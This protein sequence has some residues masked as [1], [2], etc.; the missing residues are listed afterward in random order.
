MLD[1]DMILGMDWFVKYGATIDCRRKM[2]TFEPEGEDPYVF[3]GT[4]HGPRV[5]MISVLRARGL[6][7][8]GCLGFLAIVVETTQVMPV[9]PEETI[10]VCEFLDVFPEDLPGLPPHREIEFVIELASGTERVSGAPYRMTPI[11]LKELKVQ[12]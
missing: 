5:P 12:L 1:F 11:E 9:G 8:S 10:L 4:V 6:L 7:Q 3:V 2:V